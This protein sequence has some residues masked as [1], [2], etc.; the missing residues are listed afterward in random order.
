MQTENRNGTC[1]PERMAAALRNIDIACG[2]LEMALAAMDLA[3]ERIDEEVNDIVPNESWTSQVFINR[4][5][6]MQS[7]LRLGMLQVHNS[8]KEITASVEDGLYRAKRGIANEG[9]NQL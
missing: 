2:E 3:D 1:D 7:T 9:I 5:P 8:L 6:M 4:F